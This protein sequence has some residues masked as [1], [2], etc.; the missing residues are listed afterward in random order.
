METSASITIQ[1]PAGEVFDYLAD[2]SNNPAWQRGQQRCEWTS[3]PPIG[4][5]STYDQEA[6]FAGRTIT[7]SFEVTE[8]EPGRRIRIVTTAGTMPIDVT[9][10]VTPIDDASCEV[11]AIVR[12]EPPMIL[13]LLGPLTRRMLRSSVAGDYVRLKAQLEAA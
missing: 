7:S 11:S 1:R 6:K 5:G 8:F 10:G 3:E 2:M 4:V 12:G 9:R 13:R